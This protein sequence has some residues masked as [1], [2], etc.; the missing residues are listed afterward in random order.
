MNKNLNKWHKIFAWI[1][2]WYYGEFYW[3]CKVWRLRHYSILNES[4]FIYYPADNRVPSQAAKDCHYKF[5]SW[6][7]CGI[8]SVWGPRTELK[9]HPENPEI[10]I[11]KLNLLKQDV[12]D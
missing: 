12:N 5:E 1:P 2:I 3:L 11:D 10:I 7:G 6:L 4:W 9:Y 8:S